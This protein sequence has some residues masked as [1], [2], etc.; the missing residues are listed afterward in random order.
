[1]WCG[2]FFLMCMIHSAVALISGGLMMFYTDEALAVGSTAH[3]RLLIRT[4]ESFSGLLLSGVG[5]V[6]FM[7]AFVKDGQFQSFFA[8]GCAGLHVAVAIWRF[9]C[10]REVEVLAGDW[11]RLAGGDIAL[12]ASW[13]LFLVHSWTDTYD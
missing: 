11:L 3:D 9:C 12:G 2:G 5:V 6:L 8:K 13:V 10:Q 7:V 1:M 4:S